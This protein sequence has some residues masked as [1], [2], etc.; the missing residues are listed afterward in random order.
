M[1]FNDRA[2]LLAELKWYAIM[3]LD[4]NLF[5]IFN[6]HSVDSEN[7]TC[8]D[9]KARLFFADSFEKVQNIL[10]KSFSGG[11]N[12]EFQIFEIKVTLDQNED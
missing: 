7:K 4:K 5:A 10:K 3:R 11:E 1:S 9:G 6:S 12:T 2:M 8:G